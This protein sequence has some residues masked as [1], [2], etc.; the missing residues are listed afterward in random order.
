MRLVKNKVGQCMYLNSGDWIENLTA[1]EFHDGKW[2]L[3]HYMDND[4]QLNVDE[5]EDLNDLDIHR[6]IK[7]VTDNNQPIEKTA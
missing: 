6:L 1:L 3:K 5:E 4:F 7:K 2:S